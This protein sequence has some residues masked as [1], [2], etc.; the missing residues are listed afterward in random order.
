MA[1]R[2]LK[3]GPHKVKPA[4]HFGIFGMKIEKKSI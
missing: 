2:D 1:F 3:E 4:N